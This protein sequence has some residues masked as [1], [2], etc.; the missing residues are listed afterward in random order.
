MAL[1]FHSDVVALI[2]TAD[3]VLNGRSDDWEHLGQAVDRVQKLQQWQWERFC[4]FRQGQERTPD[5]EDIAAAL[6]QDF[7][8][9]DQALQAIEQVCHGQLDSGELE[10]WVL[11]LLKASQRI[12]KASEELERLDS[13][14]PLSV[15]PLLHDFLRAGGNVARKLESPQAL[16]SRLKPLIG[17]VRDLDAD[18]KLESELFE[19]LRS[20]DEEFQAIL[21]EMK[22]GVGAAFVFLESG[23]YPDLES[24]LERLAE[25]GQELAQFVQTAQSSAADKAIHSP[26]REIERWAIRRATATPDDPGVQEAYKEVAT[27]LQVHQRQLAGLGEIPFDSDEYLAAFE[28]VETALGQEF[29]AY[30]AGDVEG[31]CEASQSYEVAL[32]GLSTTLSEASADLDEAPALQELRRLVL[33]VYYKQTPRRFLRAMLDTIVP[34]FQ[35]ALAVETQDDGRAAL[36]QCL[37][38]CEHAISGLDDESVTD[39]VD[40]WRLLNTGGAA[41]LEVQARRIVEE[42]AEAEKRRVP[43]PSCG[44]RNEP[45]STTCVCGVR[46]LLATAGQLEAASSTGSLSLKEGPPTA[47]FG[48]SDPG[49]ANLAQL[50]QLAERIHSGEAT[51]TDILRTLEPHMQR[52]NRL[53]ESTPTMG[54]ARFFR[55]SVQK[56]QQGLE[57]LAGQARERDASRLT[58]GVELLMEAG[59]E[60]ETFRAP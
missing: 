33:G 19:D 39:L 41:L 28:A 49:F 24:G 30:E 7:Q 38:A 10:S 46:L 26:Y 32:E 5:S 11:A 58:Q 13:T 51:S 56:F 9:R 44:V 43:C 15:F 8:R 52:A 25:A 54:K 35:R 31:L 34:G 47:V 60:L 4:F 23:S 16:S 6:A 14:R 57:Q 59:Q 21:Q 36:G 29:A 2:N 53:L 12:T 22:E 17:W 50:L 40:A 20:M 1:I 27:L 18:W 37:Q 55:Q 45:T 3:E 48:V 42:E